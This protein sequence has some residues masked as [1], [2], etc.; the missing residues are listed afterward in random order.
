M[1]ELLD[2]A[3]PVQLHRH[4]GLFPLE[5]REVSLETLHG[6][7]ILHSLSRPTTTSTLLLGGKELLQL[8]VLGLEMRQE[9]RLRGCN[10]PLPLELGE[11]SILLGL[12]YR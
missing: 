8:I 12:K 7:A 5:N 3:E 4:H 9:I 2:R 11:G 1:P 6:K 10:L